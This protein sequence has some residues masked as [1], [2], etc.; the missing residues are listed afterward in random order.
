MKD[1]PLPRL[2]GQR[3]EDYRSLVG[4]LLYPAVVR[5]PDLLYSVTVLSRF[6]AAPTET[7]WKAAILALRYVKGTMDLCLL[8]PWGKNEN[9]TTKSFCTSM[10]GGMDSWTMRPV[11]STGLYTDSD[12]F[13]CP[14]TRRSTSGMCLLVNGGLVVYG[15]KRQDN[16]AVDNVAAAEYVAANQAVKTCIILVQ[17]LE[18][19]ATKTKMDVKVKGP[20]PLYCDN[21]AA[22]RTGTSLVDRQDV[23]KTKS[24][25]MPKWK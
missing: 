18:E 24:T 10:R 5:R 6:L 2:L 20:M 21:Q 14:D 23:A 17:A 15:C 4:A 9:D 11:S 19:I 13:G 3:H 16:V 12:A 1:D 8:F 25:C 7:H 22:C